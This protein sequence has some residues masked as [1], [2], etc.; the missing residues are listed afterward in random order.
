MKIQQF[1]EKAIEGGWDEKK[2]PR[3]QL[4]RGRY[5]DSGFP[6]ELM[7]LDP[8]A[9]QAVG[10]V[11]GW[12]KCPQGIEDCVSIHL[13][14]TL[15]IWKNMLEALWLGKTIEQYLEML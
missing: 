8:L 14:N 13:G 6:H 5:R 1:I 10:K 11:E 7:F 3:M 4:V 2:N 12:D 9:W 15:E